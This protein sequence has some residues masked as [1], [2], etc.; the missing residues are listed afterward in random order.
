[1]GDVRSC[2][3]NDEAD[4]LT[5]AVN[6]VCSSKQWDEAIKCVLQY[7]GKQKYYPEDILNEQ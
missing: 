3:M 6:N 4:L 7:K 5:L 2:H 1:M